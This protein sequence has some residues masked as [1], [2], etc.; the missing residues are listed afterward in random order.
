MGTAVR[1]LSF[2]VLLLFAAS[3]PLE[4]SVRFGVGRISKLLGVVLLVT[5]LLALASSGLRR[6]PR[7]AHGWASAFVAWAMLSYFWTLAPGPTIAKCLTLIQ[8]LGIVFIIHDL[9]SDRRELVLV[10]RAFLMGSLGATFV[11][12][13]NAHSGNAAQGT[14][15]FASANAG[16]NNT[17]CLL[18]VAVMMACFAHQTDDVRWR[19]FYRLLVPTLAMGVLFT[20]SRT[21]LLA[22]VLGAVVILCTKR[23]M[24]PGRLAG[25]AAAGVLGLVLVLSYVPPGS[26]ARL[27]TTENE[28][29]SGTLNNRTT[30]WKTSF[31][32]WGNHP[33]NGVGAG[34]FASENEVVGGV[35]AVA[36]NA[37]I[38][39]TVELGVVGIGLWMAML[40]TTA[41]GLRIAAPSVRR[42]W[43]AIGLTWV[44]GASGLTWEVRKITWF[45]MALAVA[46]GQIM[47]DERR[48]ERH[49]ELLS[50]PYEDAEQEL[51]APAVVA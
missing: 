30:Y 37:F 32:V 15:R 28:I 8:M 21:A 29:S 7:L 33:V 36:H 1:R 50:T 38:S 23:N 26:I 41:L 9:V 46:L 18:A 35:A 39:I 25:I 47:L 2:V 43:V 6:L 16:P 48:A 31:E 24:T 49:A 42:S 40:L 51:P 27:L 13:L 17:G 45:L 10:V 20:A 3:I 12:F 34:A 4:D 22:L 14:V 19:W 11:T 44:I 5:W